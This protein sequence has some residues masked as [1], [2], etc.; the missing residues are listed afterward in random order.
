M[1]SSIMHHWKL[2]GTILIFTAIICSSLVKG[3]P[4][5]YWSKRAGQPEFSNQMPTDGSRYLPEAKETKRI[6]K[7]ITELPIHTFS[8]ILRKIKSYFYSGQVSKLDE[9]PSLE[10][11]ENVSL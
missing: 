9:V 11:K 5:T 8:T 1:S 2:P 4:N 6:S 7:P 10:Q 3:K